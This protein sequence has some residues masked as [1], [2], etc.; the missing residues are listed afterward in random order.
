M[1]IPS[2]ADTS[3]LMDKALVLILTGAKGMTMT[4]SGITIML[5]NLKPLVA[6]QN[7]ELA[8]PHA[9]KEMFPK[10][11]TSGREKGSK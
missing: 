11:P 9:G 5:T 2:M 10:L 4:A 1:D 7:G 3:L 8:Q 6:G